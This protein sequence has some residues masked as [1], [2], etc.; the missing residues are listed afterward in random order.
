MATCEILTLVCLALDT[1]TAHLVDLNNASV[2]SVHFWLSNQTH[3][4]LEPIALDFLLLHRLL[5]TR[6][7]PELS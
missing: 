4:L 7:L 2:K 6:E 3:L 1:T 5:L